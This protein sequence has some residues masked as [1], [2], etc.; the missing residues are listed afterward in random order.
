MPLCNVPRIWIWSG[1][2][3]DLTDSVPAWDR[4]F[5]YGMAV[6]ESI[7]CDSGRARFWGQHWQKLALSARRLGWCLP[8]TAGPFAEALLRDTAGDGFARLYLTAGDGGPTAPVKNPRLLLFYEPRVR[9]VPA[10]Y[11]LVENPAPHIPRPAGVKSAAYWQN[12]LAL[13]EAH[14]RG[15]D[16]TLLYT[17][18]GHLIGAAMAN[19]FLLQAGRWCTPHPSTGTREGVMRQWVLEKWNV[20][21]TLLPRAQCQTADALF[22]TNSW[23][24]ILP[25][26]ELEGVPKPVPKEVLL[27]RETAEK[28]SSTGI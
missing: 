15:A 1:S 3:F 21:Q 8:P 7:R 27:L 23:I 16:E 26:T 6:F 17:P 14:S 9:A 11:R 19:V 12:I 25:V 2:E 24:G 20:E 10:G 5:R 18:E 22:L 28:L 13:E 4:G